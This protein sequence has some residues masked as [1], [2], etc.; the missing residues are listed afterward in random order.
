MLG[1]LQLSDF[2][3]ESGQVNE[4]KDTQRRFFHFL[5]SSRGG[6][7]ERCPTVGLE[8]WSLR[9]KT[10]STQLRSTIVM[11]SAPFA[12]LLAGNNFSDEF[13]ISNI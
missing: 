3:E 11:S 1:C 8:L 13:R 4:I 2:A 5:P 7:E 6:F 12:P 10:P 9:K